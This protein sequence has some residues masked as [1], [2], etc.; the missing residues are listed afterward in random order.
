MATDKVDHARDRL[1]PAVVE[2][3]DAALVKHLVQVEKVQ[4][5]VVEGVPAVDI[6]KLDA[7]TVSKQARQRLEIGLV[8]Q[9]MPVG[10]SGLLNG[11][12]SADRV[13]G[14]LA[15]VDGGEMCVAATEDRQC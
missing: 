11:A 3:D 12:S 7:L 9:P 8:E 15:R 2:G 10:K 4:E 14:L 5:H 13:V 6:G 1:H